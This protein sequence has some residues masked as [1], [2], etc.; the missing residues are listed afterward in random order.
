MDFSQIK[1]DPKSADLTASTEPRR[2]FQYKRMAMGLKES[3]IM[4][5]SAVKLTAAEL[6]RDEIE[7]YLDD[8]MVFSETFKNT[9]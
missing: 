3:P 5:A 8:I 2:S 4:F 7:I 1:M 9:S 6:S